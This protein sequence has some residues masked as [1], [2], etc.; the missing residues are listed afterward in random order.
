MA[1]M[2]LYKTEQGPVVDHHGQLFRLDQDWN[3]LVNRDN[4]LQ[5]LSQQVGRSRPNP[6]LSSV[7][8]GTLKP[9]DN[10][11]VWAAG[12]TY[13]RS[14][15][16]RM[17]ESREAGGGDFYDRVYDADRPEIFLKA[18]AHRT[19]GPGETMTLRRDSSWIV[20][21]PELVLAINRDG[22]IFG[23]AIG[24]DL[25]C[26]DIEGENPLY[27]PQAKTFDRCAAVGPCI[28]I[29]ENPPPPETMIRLTILRGGEVVISDSTT[30]DQ[31]KRG[32]NE[33][34][35]YLFRDNEHPS[36]CLLMTGTGIVPPDDFSLQ[37]GDEVQI[38]IDGIGTL[39][40]FMD[41]K[42]A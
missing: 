10:Q 39:I 1:S 22:K 28:L 29:S 7:L 11:E 41:G 12:V 6:E 2:L 19:V 8:S 3:S 21:E 35:E 15:S 9:L 14:K 33:L 32:F 34:V 13:F 25:S 37:H 30:L 4:L 18:T 16:A 36:G 23:Y 24:N 38:S 17:E 40:N 5:A 27:L 26:R 42:Q 20:P 31:I